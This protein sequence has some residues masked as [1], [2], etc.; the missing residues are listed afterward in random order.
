MHFLAVTI[1][2]SIS[3]QITAFNNIVFMVDNLTKNL[4]PPA[5]SSSKF[6]NLFCLQLIDVSLPCTTSVPHDGSLK[7]IM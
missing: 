6:V 1:F 7:E 4:T 5:F 2:A 3:Y